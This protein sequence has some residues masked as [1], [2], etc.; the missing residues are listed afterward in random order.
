MLRLRVANGGRTG[1]HMKRLQGSWPILVFA[2]LF[3]VIPL[4]TLFKESFDPI[5][6]V[7]GI[8]GPVIAGLLIAAYVG[9]RRK[10]TSE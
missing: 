1:D 3:F 5:F 10:P 6:F 9:S 4:S 2:I 7:V 8:F